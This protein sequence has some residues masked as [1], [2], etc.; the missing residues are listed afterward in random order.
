MTRLLARHRRLRAEVETLRAALARVEAEVE[1][2]E[3]FR[4]PKRG[5][6]FD[7]HGRPFLTVDYAQRF[8]RRALSWEG[9][10]LPCCNLVE[11]P[12]GTATPCPGV[13]TLVDHHQY[14]CDTCRGYCGSLVHPSCRAALA[15]PP[16]AGEGS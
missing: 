5:M 16:E 10:A 3:S 12:D 6:L 9:Q 14:R 7:E 13:M 11:Q 4:D 1:H 8:I 2:W 15:P